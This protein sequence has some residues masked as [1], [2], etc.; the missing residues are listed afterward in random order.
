M[1]ER[2]PAWAEDVQEQSVMPYQEQMDVLT[3]IV[4]EKLAELLVSRE[5]PE[6]RLHASMAYSV[7]AGGKRFRPI[8]FL[9]VGRML[10]GRTDDLLPYACAL[11][12]IHTY[13]LIHDDL[14]AMDNDDFRRGMP[15]NHKVYG[16]AMAILAG[17]ALLNRA[18]ELMVEAAIRHGGSDAE[19]L[20]CG[21]HAIRY[22][23]EASGA[24]GMVGGQVIDMESEGR[25]INVDL[26]ARMHRLKTGA[27]IRA[28]AVAPA[29]LCGADETVVGLLTRYAEQLGLAFQI[30]DD[31]LDVESTTAVLG[32]PVGSDE[33]NRKSTYVTLLGAEG[34]RKALDAAA[35]AALSA[36]EPFGGKAAFLV[37]LTRFVAERQN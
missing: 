22:I 20:A 19:K 29:L 21:L 33:R 37:D 17:D 27:L 14:P 13:S 31:L 9:A 2:I 36:L 10:G 28:S 26:L 35:N 32:K 12:H 1:D 3:R 11:E 4:E 7:S 8:L 34:A 6:K 18:F 24:S 23:A 25:T 15:T 5:V 30:R 16:E